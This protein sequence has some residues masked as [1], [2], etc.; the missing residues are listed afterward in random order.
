MQKHV[1]L[2]PFRPRSIQVKS[3]LSLIASNIEKNFTVS[4]SLIHSSISASNLESILITPKHQKPLFIL[5]M[6]S[7]YGE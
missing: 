2:K 7:S 1:P 6:L 3:K 4:L 5:S